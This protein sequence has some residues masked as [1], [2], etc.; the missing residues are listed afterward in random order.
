MR[1]NK[2]FHVVV[3]Q[4]TA[5]KCTKI[6]NAR[7]QPL[8]WSLNLLFGGVLVTV[9]VVVCLHIPIKLM[10]QS[11]SF[12]HVVG[13]QDEGF[14]WVSSCGFLSKHAVTL[15]QSSVTATM[16]FS[17]TYC[18]MLSFYHVYKL[19]ENKKVVLTEMNS[20]WMET[21]LHARGLVAVTY[22]LACTH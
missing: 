16:G 15:F 14:L 2:S 1:R 7:A 11:T 6:Y 9:A 18:T 5:K 19:G 3:L 17:P 10:T 21:N 22:P 13:R 12:C 20:N 8:F 4:R